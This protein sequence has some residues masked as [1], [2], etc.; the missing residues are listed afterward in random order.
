MNAFDKLK[1]A[2]NIG[3]PRGYKIH[4]LKNCEV[5]HRNKEVY[6]KYPHS[7]CPK[8][9]DNL[10]RIQ[11]VYY[12]SITSV[13]LQAAGIISQL[14]SRQWMCWF[15][16]NAGRSFIFVEALEKTGVRS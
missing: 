8:N 10:H 3:D 11:H 6:N 4:L 9:I 13:Q 12:M 5:H 7:N 15:Y 14:V 1:Y 2:D 16:R